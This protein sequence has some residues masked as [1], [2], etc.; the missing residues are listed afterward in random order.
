MNKTKLVPSGILLSIMGLCIVGARLQNI[1]LLYAMLGLICSL[2]IL[3]V[4][5]K[6]D[7]GIYPY[8]VFT[9]G[10]ALLYQTTLMSN[11]LV[12]TDIHTE[13][14]FYNQAVKNGWDSSIPH[15]YNSCIGTTVVAPFLTNAFNIPGYWIYK[16][17][18]PLL[19]T[20]VPVLLYFIYKK[21]FGSKVA[22]LSCF[23]FFTVPTWSLEL[24]G[25]PRQMLAELMFAGCMFLIMISSLAF[26]YRIPLVVLLGILSLM[27][28]YGTGGAI[29][30]YTGL[31]AFFL[32]F[33]KHRLF[34]AKYMALIFIILLAMGIG[35][36][37]YICEG[38]PLMHL[39]GSSL[40]Q[41]T[42]MM[43]GA[44]PPTVI[45][46][47]TLPYWLSLL[48]PTEPLVRTALG[49]DFMDAGFLG[50]GFRIF[51]IATQILLVLGLVWLMRNRKRVSAEYFGLAGV[52]VTL[53]LVCIA[54]PG[55]SNLLNI[56]RFYHLALF[57]V[58]PCVVLASGG[59]YKILVMGI[60]LPYFLFTSGVVFEVSK[61]EEVGNINIPYSIALSHDRVEVNAVFEDSD[62]QARDYIIENGLKPIYA[63]LYGVFLLDEDISWVQWRKDYGLFPLDASKVPSGAYIFLRDR[64]ER[65]SALTFK[66]LLDSSTSGMRVSY[67]YNKV[68]LDKL[69]Y[70]T[71]YKVGNTKVVK[72]R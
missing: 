36:Y 49:L 62:L 12:G 4:F 53:L 42:K 30:L 29:V 48:V 26:K 54:I 32:L 2:A 5:D 11:G 3:V 38:V 46:D 7:K 47:S 20:A 24:I 63:D 50:K 33:L 34:P 9:I 14:Y 57:L 28:H 17:I 43:P 21:E 18:F 56:T 10:L 40:A 39:K 61:C 58:A 52:S 64:N 45:T 6:M 59:H 66:P 70:D 65:K 1:W 13:Y 25:L 60:L 41:I 16:V 8:A 68:G 55:F 22:F 67:S 31:G 44:V 37:G 15:A 72:V 51:Q 69:E 27:S 71:V 23:F 19:F 35:Y